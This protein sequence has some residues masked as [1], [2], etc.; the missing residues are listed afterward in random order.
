MWKSIILVHKIYQ[1]KIYRNCLENNVWETL[2]CKGD[3]PQARKNH[4]AV[5]VGCQILIHG[6]MNSFS[7]CLKDSFILDLCIFV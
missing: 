3:M 5:L 2:Y 7:K 4:I 1:L 6:G